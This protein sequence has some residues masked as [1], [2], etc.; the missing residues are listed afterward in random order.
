MKVSHRIAAAGLWAI[1][2]ELADLYQS[3]RPA[4]GRRFGGVHLSDP[5][6]LMPTVGRYARAAR[7]PLPS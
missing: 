7:T 1:G 4:A 5:A 6:A 3:R 2:R